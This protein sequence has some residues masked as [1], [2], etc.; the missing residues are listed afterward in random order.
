M[1]KNA[2]MCRFRATWFICQLT[3]SC[4]GPY[5]KSI[6][7]HNSRNSYGYQLFDSLGQIYKCFVQ[8]SKTYCIRL[9]YNAHHSWLAHYLLGGHFIGNRIVM[10]TEASPLDGKLWQ[11]TCEKNSHRACKWHVYTT[12]PL[13]CMAAIFIFVQNLKIPGRLTWQ[14]SISRKRS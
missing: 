6:K 1:W 8:P 3:F 10:L 5:R 9:V 12:G 14:D 11:G 2:I 7:R 4:F 13:S